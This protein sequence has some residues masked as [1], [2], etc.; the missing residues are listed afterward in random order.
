[1]GEG[2]KN[3][4][5][6]RSLWNDPVWSSVIAFIICNIITAICILVYALF[7]SNSI[8]QTFTEFYNFIG[9]EVKLKIWVIIIILLGS[10]VLNFKRTIEFIYE[11]Y[12]KV[13]TKI[14]IKDD[15]VEN[16]WMPD[17][18]VGAIFFS[19]RLS[20]AFPGKRGMFTIDNPKVATKRLKIVLKE[21]LT[22][23]IGAD[24]QTKFTPIGLYRGHQND[25]IKNFNILKNGIVLLNNREFRINRIIVNRSE[26]Y[27]HD[28]IFVEV[29]GLKQTGIYNYNNDYVKER[30][31]E[32]GYFD[33]EYAV[34][35]TKF[36]RE[37]KVIREEFD[38]RSAIIRGKVKELDNPEL[39][40][41]S[42]S[43]FNFLITSVNSPLNCREFD[44]KSNE[45]FKLLLHKK[46]QTEEFLNLIID[47]FKLKR[48]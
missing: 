20:M 8:I 33:E 5:F 22:F 38:D 46:I 26:R 6:I 41:R 35:K 48:K 17:N 24:L 47:F 37:I 14:I 21:P 23:N 12:L 29:T 31:L 4:E 45:Y 10:I 30:I 42:L 11:I 18:K 16:N 19:N 44:E 9:S 1:M 43:N 7:S 13:K 3:T 25:S 15:N 28:F 34:V 40:V 2:K 39:R 36:Y 27:K 32:K